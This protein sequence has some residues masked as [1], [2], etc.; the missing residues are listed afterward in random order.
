[1]GQIRIHSVSPRR[2]LRNTLLSGPTKATLRGEAPRPKGYC[3]GEYGSGDDR[4]FVRQLRGFVR[5]HDESSAGLH[6]FGQILD[7]RR[8]EVL[9][10]DLEVAFALAAQKLLGRGP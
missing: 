5:V 3:G 9:K 6:P 2:R 7:V 1:M 8:S 4:D 10:I